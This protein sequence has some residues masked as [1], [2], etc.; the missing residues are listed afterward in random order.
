MMKN[1]IRS[2][3]NE[4]VNGRFDPKSPTYC[5]IEIREHM[6]KVEPYLNAASGLG[7][8]VKVMAML[9]GAIAFI[10]LLKDH[11]LLK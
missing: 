4:T 3:V 1:E 11:I 2:A 9:A 8:I 7:L 10:V 5:M 6:K